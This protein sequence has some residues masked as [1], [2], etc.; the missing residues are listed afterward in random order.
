MRMSKEIRDRLARSVRC[1]RKERGWTQEELAER[2]DLSTRFIQMIES[3]Q[4]AATIDTVD[5][6]SRAFKTPPGRLLD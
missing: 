2:S 5:A 3:S 6:L 1:L 4:K